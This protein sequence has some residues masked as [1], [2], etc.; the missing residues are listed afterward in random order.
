MMFSNNYPPSLHNKAQLMKTIFQIAKNELRNLF[1]SPIAWF[2]LIVFLVMCAYFYTGT[3]YS[4]AKLAHLAYSNDPNWVYRATDSVTSSIFLDNDGILINVLQSIYLFVPLLTMGIISREIN[5]GTIKLLYSSPVKLSRIILGK[6]LALMIYNL[7]LVLIL[8]IFIISGFFDIKSL[9]YGPLLSTLLGFYL[10]LCTFTAIGFYMSSLTAY[11]IV[12]AIASFT[13]FFALM[14][15]GRLWQQYDFVRD[16]TWF[17]SIAGRTEKMVTGLITTKDVIYYIII[18]YLFVSF[19]LLKLQGERE[20]KPWF[21]KAGRYV[22]VVLSGLLI[23]YISS[24]SRFTGYWDTTAGKT[25]TLL[26]HSQKIIKSFDDGPLEVTLYTNLLG[27]GAQAGLP[28]WRNVYLERCWENYLRFNWNIHFKY[29]YYYDADSTGV[30]GTIFKEFPGKSLEQIAV[31]VAKVL[32]V[33]VS[34]FKPPAEMRRL[35]DLKP[36]GYRLVMQLKYKGRAVFLRTYGNGDWPRSPNMDATLERLLGTKMPKIAFISGELERSI[37][38]NG[39]REFFQQTISKDNSGALVNIGFDVDTVNLATQDIAPDVTTVVLADPKMDLGAP[40]LN[41]LKS[42]IDKGGN[43]L[44]MGEP[45]KQHILN[46]LLQKTGFQ[47]VN[48]KLAQP[49]YNNAPDMVMPYMTATGLSMAK[50]NP[51]LPMNR[52]WTNG[53]YDDS[54]KLEMPSAMGIV[55]SGDS[56]FAAKPLFATVPGAVWSKA[57]KFVTDSVAPVF[58]PQ[59]GDIQINSFPT[60]IQLTRQINN[61]EQRMIVCGDADFLSDQKSY[62]SWV[63]RTFY[64]WL[65]DGRMPIYSNYPY[66]SDN[67]LSLSPARATVQRIAYLWVLPGILLFLSTVLLIRRKRK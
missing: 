58:S 20:S 53:V 51:A 48:G 56:G 7:L 6:Y 52:L 37:Y 12:S 9:D 40:V 45:G 18:I 42:Y 24:R 33:D 14:N 57:G 62:S 44:I 46:P 8:S 54:L 15:I 1:Y 49:G 3:T 67:M 39:E 21:V 17:L 32:K 30:G 31:E 35:I 63:S 60:C 50:E 25:N 23:G 4:W 2:L 43:M 41:K 16:F 38:K 11:P 61:R 55:N 22:A 13:V 66:A 29:E 47:Y 5:S 28:E 19:T 10:L 26:P 27:A 59:E 34:N 65:N 64:C 36:E